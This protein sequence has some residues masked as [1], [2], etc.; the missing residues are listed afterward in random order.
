MLSVI[1]CTELTILS[2]VNPLF[3]GEFVSS[4]L[5]EI[6]NGRPPTTPQIT[7]ALNRA[8]TFLEHRTKPITSTQQQVIILIFLFVSHSK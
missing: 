2:H 4:M 8:A 1:T 7:E 5:Q 3:E 6:L